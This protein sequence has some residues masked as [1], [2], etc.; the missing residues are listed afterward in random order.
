MLRTEEPHPYGAAQG[1]VKRSA[2]A[3][4][5][6]RPDVVDRGLAG[7]PILA[8]VERHLLAFAQAGH[9]GALEGRGVD[10]H[11]LAAVVRLDEAIALL[12][13]VELHSAR[14]HRVCPLLTWV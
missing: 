2:P 14:I 9:P 10:E 6:L 13:I 1:A 8:G 3:G 5:S 11:V 4:R 12:I 7:A